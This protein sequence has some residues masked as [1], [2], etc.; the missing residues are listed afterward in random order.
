VYRARDTRLERTVAIKILPVEIAGQTDARA[1]FER[2]ARAIAAL[3]HLHI[4]AVYDVGEHDGLHY[5]VMQHLEGETLAA[6]LARLKGPLPLDQALPIA[7][8]IAD[9]LDKTHRAGITRRDLKPANIMLTK[10]GAKLLDFG[11]AKLRGPA[12]PISLS[13]M[14]RLATATPQTAHGTILGTVQYMAPEQVE[15]READARS[16]I[17]AFGAVVYE[18]A[19]GQ[20]P[21][22]G[23]SPAS[24]I[25]AI[26]KDS[27]PPV[28]ARQPVAP[29]ALDHLVERCLAKDPD[30]RWQHI[31]DVK[32][33]L[34]S[35]ASTAGNI[36]SGSAAARR[37]P[38]VSSWMGAAGVGALVALAAGV[39]YWSGTTAEPPATD[40]V[41]LAL[42][43]GRDASLANDFPIA[44][45]S[46]DGT[47]IVFVSTGSDG[48]NRLSTRRLDQAEATPLPGTERAYSPFFSP[49]GEW[50]G[51]F[52]AGKLKK[53]RLDGGAPLALCDAPAGRGASWSEDGRIIAALDNRSGLSMVSSNGGAVT[54]VT[55]LIAGDLSHRWPHV[56][57][58][59]KTVLFTVGSV[60]GNYAAASI[61]VA[62]LENNPG[63]ARKIVHANAGMF[64]RYLSTGHLVYIANATLLAVPFDVSTLDVRGTAVPVLEDLSA[65]TAFGSAQLAFSQNGTLLYRSGRT[66][67]RAVLQ[68]LQSDGKT[69]S[70]WDEPAFY[71]FPHPS[72]DGSRIVSVVSDGAGADIWVYDWRRGSKTRLSAGSG[73][74]TYPVWSPDGQ[75]VVF[76]A[77]GQL[78]WARADGAERP[79]P[80]TKSARLRFPSSFTP[81]GK[82]LLFF[83]PDPGGGSLIQVLPIDSSA[84]QLRAAEPELFR[85]VDSGNPVPA[86][87]PDGRWVAY[88]SSESGLYEV[89]VRAFPDKGQQAQVSTSGGTFP[90]WSRTG[91]ELF[92][93]TE[94]HHLMVSTYTTEGDVF[95]AGRPR[96]WSERPLFNLGLTQNFDLA[97]D[98]KRFAVL[99]SAESP[100][101]GET[102]RRVTLV[103]NVFD[104]VRRR[105]AA[106]Q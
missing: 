39:L 82:R 91:N 19:T 62:S 77:T 25:G 29:P 4:C 12:G 51:F 86:V 55:E 27:P 32:H 102:Q 104:E 6:R 40:P 14:T 41:R 83:E 80:L 106:G 78:F 48:I 5:L 21:F 1:R 22:G 7:I 16:D 101:P 31:G 3:D 63:R 87:S 13:G 44:T 8:A 70:L 30:E 42:E 35:I 72:P 37:R 47:R 84:G 54:P 49:D 100:K 92:Y 10:T 64:P 36:A 76:Q 58:G 23:D 46:P 98:G 85:H 90:V 93:R 96:L 79:Q 69:E 38:P 88:A 75:Y 89:Y 26:L 28:S 60:P 53:T 65:D 56:L 68:W 15:G 18:M 97:P 20:R 61:A 71:Q 34:T 103:L 81:D 9:A 24:V 57:P 95:L 2:E 11:L 33:H 66:N 73:V 74:N 59:G 45:L 17:W 67:G 52:A 94:D 99:M 43:L 50:V 105:V